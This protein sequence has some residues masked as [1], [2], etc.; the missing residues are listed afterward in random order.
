MDDGRLD[1]F[2]RRLLEVLQADARLPVPQIAERVGL[3]SPA[4]YRRIRRLREIGALEREIAVVRAR[5]M[6]WPLT[7]LVLV[8]MERERTH[9]IDQF[10]QSLNAEPEIIEAWYVTGDHD[11]VLRMVA[12]DME[13]Y[14]DLATRLFHGD[15]NVRNFKTLVVLRNSKGL[16]PIPAG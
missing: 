14:D 8:T 10:V 3:S 9:L 6:G 2:D 12:R 11:F 4:C 16:S 13:S 1:A 5:T 7:M 15:N